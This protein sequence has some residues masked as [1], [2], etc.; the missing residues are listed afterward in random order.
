MANDDETKDDSEKG[1]ARK[2]ATTKE[3]DTLT[4]VEKETLPT[5]ED[6]G[7]EIS[8]EATAQKAAPTG[9]PTAEPPPEASIDPASTSGEEYSVLTVTQKKLVL[10]T[11][12]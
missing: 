5:R 9:D 10:L 7:S 2:N 11:A 4:A 8:L 1:A 6:L 12:S 3:T